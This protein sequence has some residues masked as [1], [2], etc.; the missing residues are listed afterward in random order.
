MKR[1]NSAY[2]F[3]KTVL[4]VTY[5]TSGKLSENDYHRVVGNNKYNLSQT[6]LE[7]LAAYLISNDMIKTAVGDQY[8]Q[9]V[10]RKVKS[11][12][13]AD[14]KDTKGKTHVN[15]D[16]Y[17][18]SKKKDDSSMEDNQATA[19]FHLNKVIDSLKEYEDEF[20]PAW[21]KR[22]ASDKQTI[23]ALLHKFA[24]DFSNYEQGQRSVLSLLDSMHNN[25]P[26]GAVFDNP[27]LMSM[28]VRVDPSGNMPIDQ[29]IR[30]AIAGIFDKDVLRNIFNELWR[31]TSDNDFKT[32]VQQEQQPE[33]QTLEQPQEFEM[34][35]G[36]NEQLDV[37]LSS[38]QHAFTPQSA[39]QQK[40]TAAVPTMST[41][42][43]SI[44]DHDFT[45]LVAED[46]WAKAAG[47]EV[48]DSLEADEGMLFPFYPQQT[49]TFHMG[50]V[51]FPIDI[52]FLMENGNDLVIGDIVESA[53]PG[54]D[55]HWTAKAKYVLELRGG[56]S[57]ELGL[58]KGMA[59]VI[60]AE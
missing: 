51:N 47:L 55:D 23:L 53:Q 31:R 12:N 7:E 18:K 21:K 25:I 52:L 15:K 16:K 34:D 39:S 44:N 40:K 48:V 19:S 5:E 37:D 50:A 36:T 22:E 27:T 43:V 45:V 10:M 57:A 13:F 59:C 3:V 4:D 28:F 32:E 35:L 2:R 56:M 41:T 38:L 54:A 58:C 6:D 8:A 60:D 14:V 11:P 42:T 30:N 9:E 26:E 33:Q 29:K 20:L 17:Q 1:K 49:V 46:A 24:Q